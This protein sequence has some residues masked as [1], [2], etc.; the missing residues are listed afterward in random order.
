M[1]LRNRTAGNSDMPTQVRCS[2]RKMGQA[3]S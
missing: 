2:E 1:K 3:L